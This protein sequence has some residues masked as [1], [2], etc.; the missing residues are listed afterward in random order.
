MKIL[1]G[2]MV[3]LAII[4]FLPAFM[5]RTDSINGHSLKTVYRSAT[6]AKRYLSTHDRIVF[7]TALGILN[8]IKS[9]ESPEAFLKAI[10]G[11]KPEEVIDLARQEVGVKIA[12]G[13]PDFKQYKSWDDMIGKLIGDTDTSSKSAPNPQPLRSSTR[14]GRPE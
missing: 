12:T 8:K 3:I 10:D 2:V 7:D 14:E 11:K 13:H 4:Y 1:A 6:Q 5:N 9:E